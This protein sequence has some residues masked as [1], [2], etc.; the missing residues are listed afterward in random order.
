MG[1][2]IN[3]GLT[4]QDGG[5]VSTGSYVVFSSQIPQNSLSYRCNLV[6][7]RS[8]AIMDAGNA[9][10]NVKGFKPFFVKT[11]NQSDFNALTPVVIQNDAKAYLETFVGAGNVAIV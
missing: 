8:K 7:Y 11:L 3:T 10:I 1:L 5:T 2:Q 9:P 6:I 4:T